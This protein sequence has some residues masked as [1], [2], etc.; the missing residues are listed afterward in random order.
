M[1][2]CV[3][4]LQ[5]SCHNAIGEILSS[6]SLLVLHLGHAGLIGTNTFLSCGLLS[7]KCRRSQ[8]VIAAFYDVTQSVHATTLFSVFGEVH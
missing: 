4:L 6:F 7:P 5:K 2:T 8:Y 1:L 3:E